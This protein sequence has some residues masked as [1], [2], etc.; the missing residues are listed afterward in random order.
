[1][2]TMKSQAVEITSNGIR[3]V[4]NKYTPERAISEFVW[5]GFDA[6]AT[7]VKIDFDFD[8]Q[9]F[10]T[11]KQIKISDNGTGICHEELS[12]K[13]KKFYESQKA[14]ANGNSNLTRGKNGYWSFYVL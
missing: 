11:V 14:I 3:K 1:M 6:K 2:I 9:L 4:I 5:N 12:N 8:N 10:D 7:V 13:F